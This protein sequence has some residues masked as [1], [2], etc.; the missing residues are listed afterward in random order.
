VGELRER[1]VAALELVQRSLRSVRKLLTVP[2][3]GSAC[4][5]S[6]REM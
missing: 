6:M 2:M 3:A 4:G 1:F 5:L